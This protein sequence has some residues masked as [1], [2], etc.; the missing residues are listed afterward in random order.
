MDFSTY[1]AFLPP[2]P[3]HSARSAGGGAV[4]PPPG[5]LLVIL[6]F[7][8]RGFDAWPLAGGK[9]PF[10]L[11]FSLS[12]A[13]PPLVPPPAV[14]LAILAV[15]SRR[16]HAWR[17]AGWDTTELAAAYR[18]RCATIGAQVMAELPGGRTLT[19]IATGIDDAGRLLIGDDAVS[20]GDVTH[21]R[22]QY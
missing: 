14:V 10:P 16:F 5:L 1:A 4:G 3:L 9:V 12:R 15:F 20:A 13:G 18:E 21:L 8:T 22:G 2:S 6:A 19:G 11:P 7:F 17:L